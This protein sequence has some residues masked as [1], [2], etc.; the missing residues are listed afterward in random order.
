LALSLNFWVNQGIKKAES[1]SRETASST[2]ESSVFEFLGKNQ[3]K[4]RVWRG[5]ADPFGIPV[6][7]FGSLYGTQVRS[8]TKTVR[9]PSAAICLF[10]STHEDAFSTQVLIC[11]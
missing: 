10:F 1:G 7:L 11:L 5:L 4:A 3:Q 2:S 6:P 8:L 9:D